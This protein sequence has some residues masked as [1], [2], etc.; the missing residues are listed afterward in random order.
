MKMIKKYYEAP[1]AEIEW[2][3]MKDVI[4]TSGGQ[5]QYDDED[6]EDGDGNGTNG[7][8]GTNSLSPEF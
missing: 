4:R 3:T 6:D 8:N 1:F 7:T 2:L 5:D